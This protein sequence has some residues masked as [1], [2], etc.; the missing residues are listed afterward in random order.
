MMDDIIKD[1]ILYERCIEEVAS[2]IFSERKIF[3][4][5]KYAKEVFHTD[6]YDK[7]VYYLLKDYIE[8]RLLY[9]FLFSK[10]E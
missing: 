4:G 1:D 8:K 5:F 9:I 10:R 7:K 3:Q 2:N 6:L